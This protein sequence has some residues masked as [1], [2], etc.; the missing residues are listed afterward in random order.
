MD[1]DGIQ[2]LAG[3]KN[4]LHRRHRLKRG[5][6]IGGA[7]ALQ[8]RHVLGMGGIL[9]GRLDEETV[10]LCLGQGE[11]AHVLH[12]ILSGDDHKGIA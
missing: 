6:R 1:E 5:Q 4:L 3:V 10:K 9:H 11:H 12:R 7:E 2:L 8:D